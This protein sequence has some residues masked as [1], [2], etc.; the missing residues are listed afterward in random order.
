[1]K[2]FRSDQLVD[3]AWPWASPNENETSSKRM[4]HKIRFLATCPQETECFYPGFHL[5]L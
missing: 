5:H 3:I 4:I 2:L 1:M